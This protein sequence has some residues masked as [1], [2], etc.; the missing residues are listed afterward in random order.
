M[1]NKTKKMM[2][3]IGAITCI[4]ITIIMLDDISAAFMEGWNHP[5]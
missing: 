3:I 1:N 5:F 2:V 4:V